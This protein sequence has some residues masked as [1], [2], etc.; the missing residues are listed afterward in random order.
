MKT[1]IQEYCNIHKNKP[2]A[3]LGG[4]PNVIEDVKRLPEGTIKISVNNHANKIVACGYMVFLDNP[5]NCNPLLKGVNDFTGIR[6]T[7]GNKQK[8]GDISFNPEDFP[9]CSISSTFALWFA[10][11]IGGNPVILCGMDLFQN[12]KQTHSDSEPGVKYGNIDLM[13]LGDH[14][15]PWVNHKCLRKENVYVCSG[16]LIGIFKEYLV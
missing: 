1:P 4:G 11:Y 12:K 10:E 13:T 9:A 3:V 8:H 15:K 5:D 14:K 16:P 6:V 7:P 2:I